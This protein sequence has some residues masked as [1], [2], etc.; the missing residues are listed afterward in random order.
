MFVW[1][2]HNEAM[3]QPSLE[4]VSASLSGA[5]ENS[6]LC[7]LKPTS[8]PSTPSSAVRNIATQASSSSPVKITIA[9]LLEIVDKDP[10]SMRG[11]GREFEIID[12]QAT[13]T[14]WL[15]TLNV[16][17]SVLTFIIPVVV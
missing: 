9:E 8:T 12:A 14:E 7:E 16:R 15:K 4:D 17:Q 2:S 13:D 6:P 5:K 3:F 10:N 1:Y 11:S